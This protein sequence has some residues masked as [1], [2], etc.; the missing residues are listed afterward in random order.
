MTNNPRPYADVLTEWQQVSAKLREMTKLELK[1]R[2]T[3][4]ELA[5]PNPV[6]G[7]NSRELDDGRIVKGTHKINRN[8]DQ[9]AVEGVKKRLAEL[10]SPLGAPVDDVF[11]AKIELGVGPYKKL[12]PEARAIANDAITSKPGTPSL[13]VV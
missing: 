1:L 9:A 2:T 10:N 6:E 3:L 7:V 8:V 11:K 4:F 5:F 13:E 12:S